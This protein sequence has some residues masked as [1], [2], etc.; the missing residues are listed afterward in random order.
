MRAGHEKTNTIFNSSPIFITTFYPM[1]LVTLQLEF[2][3]LFM[4]QIH[5][6]PRNSRYFILVGMQYGIYVP[7]K[8]VLLLSMEHTQ[9]KI[10]GDYSSGLT[11]TSHSL[12]FH[13]PRPWQLPFYFDSMDLKILDVSQK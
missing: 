4:F 3:E 1:I 12:H 11:E 8:C 5:L 10:S 2:Q 7:V 9:Y 13:T 6:F